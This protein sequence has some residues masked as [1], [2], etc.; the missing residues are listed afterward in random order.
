MTG[1]T[2]LRRL[3]ATVGLALMVPIGLQLVTGTLTP[4]D[5]A[6]RA[7]AVFAAVWVGRMLAGLAPGNPPIVIAEPSS[8]VE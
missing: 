1:R 8:D 4:A 3:I 6:T 7:A 5:A 2:A